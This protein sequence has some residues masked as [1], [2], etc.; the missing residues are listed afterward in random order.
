[1][2]Y[3]EQG[4]L[5]VLKELKIRELILPLTNRQ[6]QSLEENRSLVY[7]NS[8][9]RAKFSN[10]ELINLWKHMESMQL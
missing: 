1:M 10:A 8:H 5:T 7:K 6:T 4:I 3:A 2:F 9:V